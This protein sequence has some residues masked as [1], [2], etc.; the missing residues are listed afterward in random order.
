MRPAPVLQGDVTAT[1]L[2]S[3]RRR[4]SAILVLAAL[5]VALFAGAQAGSAK[6]PPRVPAGFF[7][8]APQ[9]M[10]T[11]QD[12][13][14][15]QAGG[16][17]SLRWALSWYLVQPTPQ[18]DY[19]WSSFDPIVELAAQYGVRV[20]PSVGGPP[21]WITRK[22]KT[23]PVDSARQ[24]QAWSEFVAAAAKRYGPGGDFWKLHQTGGVGVNYQPAIPKPL[25]IREW[26]IWNES[27]FFYF[28]FPVSPP[29]YAQLVTVASKAIKSVSPGAKVVLSGLFAEPT[30]GG[31]RGMPAVTYLQRLYDV[32][33][34]KSRFDGI[35]LHPYAVDAETLEELVEEFH[36][37]AIDNGDRPSL[38]ITE[39]GWGSQNNFEQVA[40]EQG[41][42]G[43]VRQLRDSYEYLLANRNRLNLK[44]VYWFSWKDVSGLCNFCDSVGFFREG[45]RFKA[46][47]AWRTFVSLTGGRARP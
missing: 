28:A 29:R 16:I 10:L 12:L 25:P 14:Y 7:G 2:D 4:I 8:I 46:K 11:T 15:M 6:P 31:K 34:F 36:D 22:A 44:Q 33:G 27:N 18:S 17:E 39:I 1:F 5:T 24:R 47:P 32:P 35:S 42:Q 23:M 45:P 20:L 21:K 43:Q 41:I 9:T 37:V 19:D 40:F 26:Q 30:V 38:Y 13:R 3:M